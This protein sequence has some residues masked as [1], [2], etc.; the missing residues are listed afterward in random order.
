MT[1]VVA[2]REESW[3]N[4]KAD[5]RQWD[6]LTRAYGVDLML[7]DRGVELGTVELTGDIVVLDEDAEMILDYFTHPEDA[8]YVFGRTGHAFLHKQIPNNVSVRIDTPNPI[9]LFGCEAAA[10]VLEHRRRQ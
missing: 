2:Y 7:L 9:C 3:M 10:I 4:P 5:W 8:I 6:H 1:T